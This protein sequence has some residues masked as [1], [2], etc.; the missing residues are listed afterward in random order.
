MVK[1]LPN[2]FNNGILISRNKLI[3][4]SFFRPK[5]SHYFFKTQQRFFCSEF[6]NEYPLKLYFGKPLENKE[7]IK[8]RLFDHLNLT[9]EISEI[10]YEHIMGKLIVFIT[11]EEFDLFP[12]D[13]KFSASR[14]LIEK[15]IL[16]QQYEVSIDPNKKYS[17][18]EIRSFGGTK[19]MEFRCISKMHGVST[20]TNLKAKYASENFDKETYVNVKPGSYK[21]ESSKREIIKHIIKC[22]GT[23][24]YIVF[25]QIVNKVLYSITEADLLLIPDEFPEI[26]AKI[27]KLVKHSHFE[28]SIYIRSFYSQDE[29]QTLE[30]R[31]LRSVARAHGIKNCL[32]PN[33]KVN[34]SLMLEKLNPIMN[35]IKE[36]LEDY[37]NSKY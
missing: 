7:L 12:K 3:F 24:T 30:V 23:L 4:G 37:D 34:V 33:G 6:N 29:L 26:R 10:Q 22:R 14:T 25:C 21:T 17:D 18:S 13:E 31:E 35:E 11:A 15:T 5:K 36:V 19:T 2:I 28:A 1:N 8:Q 32:G 16:R 27:R 9:G 20:L